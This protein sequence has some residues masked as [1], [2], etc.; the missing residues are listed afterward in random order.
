VNKEKPIANTHRKPS[1]HTCNGLCCRHIALPLDTPKSKTDYDN[2]RWF[3]MHNR[4][5]VGIDHEGGWMIEVPT[6]CRHLKAN[7]RC[8]EYENRPKLCKTFPANEPCEHED[9]NSPYKVLFKDEKDLER[10]LGKRNI[11]WR[12]K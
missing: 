2:L 11:V 10:Y 12:L 9:D 8:A 1:C 7:N 6:L 5:V 4:I 3:L